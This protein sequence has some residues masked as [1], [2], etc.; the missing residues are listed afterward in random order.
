MEYYFE[1]QVLPDPEFSQ[2]MLM[3]ALFAK[4]HRTLVNLPNNAIA[5]SFPNAEAGKTRNVGDVL[6]IHGC[7][8]NLTTLETIP[9]RKGLGEYTQVGTIARV[10]DVKEFRV[11]KRVQ[12]KSSAER[13]RRRAA[14]RHELSSQ[15][16][17]TRIPHEIEKKLSQPFLTLKSS[18]TGQQFPLFIDQSTCYPKPQ[19]GDFSKYGLSQRATVPWF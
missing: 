11:I 1:I 17:E 2:H 6:R 3:N 5:I 12:S 13:L 8:A 7:Q 9:W 16:A 15:Q 19:P 4:L 10:P 14:R 18:S